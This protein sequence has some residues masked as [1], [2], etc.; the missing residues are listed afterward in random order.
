MQSH[1]TQHIRPT[2]RQDIHNMHRRAT[3]CTT[4]LRTFCNDSAGLVLRHERLEINRLSFRTMDRV[5]HKRA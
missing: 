1:A 2:A 3:G 4:R 5:Y